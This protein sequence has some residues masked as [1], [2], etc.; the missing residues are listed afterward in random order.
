[1]KK[2]LITGAAGFIGRHAAGLFGREGWHVA[3]MDE[4]PCEAAEWQ[5]WGVS[6]WH[7]S[8]VSL[9]TL[10]SCAGRP[11]VI[12]H[13]AGTGVVG[14]SMTYPFEDYK[15]N[16]DTTMAVLE[17]VRLHAP[18]ARVLYPSSAAVYGAAPRIP[19]SEQDEL[20]PITPYGVHKK[21]AEDLCRSYAEHF[22]LSVAVIRF[23]SVYGPG[24]RKQLLWDAC[25]RISNNENSFWGL[26]T[27]VRDWVHVKDAVRLFMKVADH[28]SPRCPVVN[29]GSGVGI[30]ICDLL[31]E[32]FRCLG[33]PD[34]P[35]FS[36][37]HRPGDPLCY[38]ADIS[39]AV[40]YGWR[41]EWDWHRGIREYV[42]W[43]KANAT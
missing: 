25:S 42:A 34:S 26:G 32:I 10:V 7:P 2:V 41:P 27:E 20:K 23:F 19:I 12:I 18:G 30:E 14:Y 36:G 17:F 38:V 9:E 6:E 8:T 13:C 33:K 16:V 3:G 5:R 31:S 4:A 39:R 29:G 28:A 43:F 35:V 24:L 11:D 15:R 40:S 1:M 21:V 22:G 37:V